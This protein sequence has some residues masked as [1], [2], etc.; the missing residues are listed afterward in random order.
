M[1][2]MMNVG[3]PCIANIRLAVRTLAQSA[4]EGSII[5]VTKLFFAFSGVAALP[6]SYILR[7]RLRKDLESL[8]GELRKNPRLSY[9]SPGYNTPAGKLALSDFRDNARRISL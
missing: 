9:C 2:M 7:W 4:S 1:V 6:A 3:V 8:R 5:S